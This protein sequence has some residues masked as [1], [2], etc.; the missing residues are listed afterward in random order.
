MHMPVMLTSLPRLLPHR[1]LRSFLTLVGCAVF[2][3]PSLVNAQLSW[4]PGQTPGA[5][6]GSGGS[7]TWNT[8]SAFW[9]QGTTDTTWNSGAAIFG[10]TTPTGTVTISNG[11]IGVSATGLTFNTGSTY[12]IQ[13]QTLTLTGS[14]VINTAGTATSTISSTLSATRLTKTGTGTLYLTGGTVGTPSSLGTGENLF[15]NGTTYVSGYLNAG[16]KTSTTTGATVNWSATG[17]FS[18]TNYFGITSAGVGSTFNVTGGSLTMSG[19]S[20]A[21][22]VGSGGS[23]SSTLHVSGGSLAITQSTRA[24]RIGAGYEGNSANGGGELTI[25]GSG[26]FTTQTTTG[27]FQLGSNLVGATNPIGDGVVNLDGGTLETNRAITKGSSSNAT[28]TFNFNGGILRARGTAMTLGGLT[29]ANVRDGGALIDTNGFNVTIS[30]A[31]EHS[32]IVGDDAFDGGLTKI[33]AGTLTLSDVNTYTGDT[34]INGG[35]LTLDQGGALTFY[36]ETNGVNN[37]VDGTGTA[38]FSGTFIFDL[39]GA[40]ANAG[41]SWM[42]VDVG[43]LSESF[44]STF[45]V[46]GFTETSAGSGVW[47]LN[48]YSFNEATG[49]LTF[50]VPGQQTLISLANGSFESW[51]TVAGTPPVGKPTFWLVGSPLPVRTAGLVAGSTHAAV[52]VP[53]SNSK[54][55]QNA[56]TQPL[57]FQLSLVFAATDPG[58][59][60]TRSFNLNINQNAGISMNLRMVR[61]STAGK[62]TL[63]SYAG[64]VWNTIAADAFDASVYNSG[65]GNFTTLN[66]YALTL[67]M[68]YTIPSYSISYGPASGGGQTTVNNLTSISAVA[69]NQGIKGVTIWGTGSATPFAIDNINITSTWAGSTQAEAPLMFGVNLAGPESGFVPGTFGVNYMYPNAAEFDYYQGKGLTFI[70]L[71]FKWERVQHSLYSALDTAEMGRMD[72]VIALA[73]ARGMKVLLDMHNYNKYRI[74]GA[75]YEVGSAQVPYSAFQDAWVRIADRYKDE[76]AIYGYDLMNEPTGTLANWQAA[77]QAAVNSIRTVDV[78]HYIFIEGINSSGAQSWAASNSTLSINDPAQKIIYSAHSYWDANHDGE[79][80]LNEQG[81]AMTG[82]NFV[83]P[84]VDWVTSHGYNGHIGE[85]GVPRNANNH[86]ASWQTSLEGFMAYLKANNISGSYWAGGPWWGDYQLSCEPTNNFTTDAVQMAVLENYKSDIVMDSADPTGITITGLWPVSAYIPG[87][88]GKNYMHDNNG[89]KGTKS[90]R[91]TPN[92][93]S[94][95]TYAVYATWSSDP[96]RASN[97]PID[98]IAADGTHTVQ[99][100][101]R[102]NGGKWVYLGTHPFNAGT[103]GSVLIRTTGTNGGVVADGIIFAP[104]N[105]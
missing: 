27:T 54:L 22:F 101:Q 45:S 77:A 60:T 9:D 58:S 16:G 68:D 24:V 44:G 76:P 85:F 43:T 4:D 7:G 81:N 66:A 73:R 98:I 18:T 2:V 3:L 34:M 38:N 86:V 21:L 10:G 30:Q 62:L 80:E 33:G 8:T 83:Q 104:E 72:A 11:G 59:S 71:P 74:S 26:L 97:V 50:G 84:F 17:T 25:S 99:V 42:I 29:R 53:G 102:I 92:L 40:S 89:H 19:T 48:G 55:H 23:V 15:S 39:T 1:V 13:G 51:D 67:S 35:G 12:T 32:E 94:A 70:R 96:S 93:I 69:P 37:R 63:Q 95:G 31:L 14:P 82:V 56:S 52:L 20:A 75:D 49:L 105:D 64:G 61:G 103:G 36:I 88:Y 57:K 90:V 91:Y 46:Q 79:Y 87:Y 47:T 78:T 6:S 5:P 41:D 28:A 100:N 65:T